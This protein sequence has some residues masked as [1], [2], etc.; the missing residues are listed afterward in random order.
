MSK[1]GLASVLG[2][3]ASWT[4]PMVAVSGRKG[5]GV[6]LLGLVMITRIGCEFCGKLFEFTRI[7]LGEK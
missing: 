4:T 1:E 2:D 6:G 3:G 7:K 5:G